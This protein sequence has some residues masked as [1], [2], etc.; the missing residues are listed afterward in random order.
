MSE[1]DESQHNS[2]AQNLINSVYDSRTYLNIAVGDTNFELLPMGELPARKVMGLLASS[3]SN[4]L[5]SALEL[6]KLASK[7]PVDFDND[8]EFVSFNE[9]LA[10]I[11][12]W[13]D[14]S[15]SHSSSARDDIVGD[16]RSRS[17]LTHGSSES[18]GFGTSKKRAGEKRSMKI[19]IES[20]GDEMPTALAEGI[21]TAI[22]EASRI[23]HRAKGN[24]EDM[25][26]EQI[27]LA[28]AMWFVKEGREAEL[29]DNNLLSA[30]SRNGKY[31]PIIDGKVSRRFGFTEEEA[32]EWTKWQ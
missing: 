14:K 7:N 23:H 5:E 22:E 6:M 28:V 26:E 24:L 17:G 4:R 1:A 20:D 16:S 9:L 11:D 31:Y 29:V 13:M 12:M 15:S 2:H 27:I 32:R 25:T 3:Q 8:A 10:A 21:A 19:E 18:F 30:K